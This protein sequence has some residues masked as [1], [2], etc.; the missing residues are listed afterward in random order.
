MVSSANVTT[1]SSSAPGLTPSAAGARDARRCAGSSPGESHRDGSGPGCAAAIPS[2]AFERTARLPS[3]RRRS[4][5][6]RTPTRRRCA[7]T[8]S[9]GPR[10]QTPGPAAVFEALDR[11]RGDVKPRACRSLRPAELAHRRRELLEVKASPSTVSWVAWSAVC[12]RRRRIPTGHG[13]KGS[14]AAR[15]GR[16]DALPRARAEAPSHARPAR[17]V[18]PRALRGFDSLVTPEWSEH[19]VAST[20]S[21][22]VGDGC[23]A[24]AST[25][26]DRALRLGGGNVELLTRPQTMLDGASPEHLASSATGVYPRVSD[27]ASRSL[28]PKAAE[29]AS[30]PSGQVS[31][32]VSL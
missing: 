5:C 13:S 26:L 32:S 18:S 2:R 12:G 22:P 17:R 24:I 16:H 21:A 15:R 1:N 19:F 30:A 9:D 29:L 7:C 28:A 3:S 25:G 11:R 4:L 20:V 10:W 8:S 31:G 14:D 23:A 27:L 6:S